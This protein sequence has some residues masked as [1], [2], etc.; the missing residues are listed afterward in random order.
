MKAFTKTKTYL[1]AAIAK[2]KV[3]DTTKTMHFEAQSNYNCVEYNYCMIQLN[4]GLL[5]T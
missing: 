5:V 4:S 1:S 3:K 2:L